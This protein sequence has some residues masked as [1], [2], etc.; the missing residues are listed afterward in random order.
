MPDIIYG[1]IPDHW[2][3]TT[4]GEVCRRGGGNIQTGP[5]GSQL[6]ASDY[7]STGI[8]SVMPTNIGE[9]RIIEDGIVRITEADANRLAQHRLRIGDIVYSRRGD[10]EKRALIR[11]RED[12][13]FCGTGCLK[14]RLGSGVVDPL[15]A[16]MFLGHPCIREWIVRHAIGATMP[17]LNTSIMSAVPFVVPPLAEQKAIARILG[18]LDDKIELNRKMN[19]TLESMARAL[20]QSWFVDFDPVRARLDGRTPVGMDKATADLFPAAF[21]D[22]ALGHIP[23]GW[24]VEP[25][26]EVVVC[27]GGGTPSTAE[28]KYWEGGTHHWATPKDLSSLQAP[29]LLNTDRKLT[30]AGVAKVSSGLLPEGTLLL[31]SRAPVGYLAI[32]AMP[33]A[34]NQGFIAVKCNKRATNFFMLNWCQANMAEIESRATGTTFAEI[35]KQNFRP[36]RVV[37]PPEKLMADFT[38]IVFPLYVQIKSNLYQSRTL[39]TLRDTLLPKLL[40]GE[41]RIKDA[42]RIVSETI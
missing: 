29:F 5:F 31:S 21:Q 26:G 24:S 7:V 8:P 36:I 1:E 23:Q 27:V 35:S 2:E 20:F 17:N 25:V 40:S 33:V 38:L 22:S 11:E 34:I 10:V 19:A 30:D 3:F 39:A 12:G 13:W 18:T 28:P 15:F 41:L 37:V 16:S 4:L 42:E 6:H 14:V 9:N 32:A